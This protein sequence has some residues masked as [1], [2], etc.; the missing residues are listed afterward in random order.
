MSMPVTH[1]ACTGS[2]GPRGNQLISAGIAQVKVAKLRVTFFQPATNRRF[3]RPAWTGQD[4]EFQRPDA[5]VPVRKCS[6]QVIAAGMSRTIVI[7]RFSALREALNQA[8][9]VMLSAAF[10]VILI[11]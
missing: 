9:I 10:K 8:D 11:L 3:S 4:Y 1:S 5:G 7:A 2:P 6:L